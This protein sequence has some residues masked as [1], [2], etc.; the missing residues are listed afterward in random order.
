[1]H[2]ATHIKVENVLFIKI[3]K[4]NYAK[5]DTSPVLQGIRGFKL[6]RGRGWKVS[7]ISV[8]S[9]FRRF[10]VVFC[11][12]FHSHVTSLAQMNSDIH[13]DHRITRLKDQI[14]QNN[15]SH[16]I[17]HRHKFMPRKNHF[18]TLN[19]DLL[20]LMLI[21]QNLLS[22]S[23]LSR[24]VNINIYRTIILPAVLYGCETWSLALREE[25]RLRI[26]ENWVL[27]RTF[28]S[29]RDKV[30]GGRRKLHNKEL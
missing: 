19:R 25:C 29:K 11:Q 12:K 15:I 6:G 23:L 26:F 2:G 17:W 10:F 24:S 30:T 8:S 13:E 20:I 1:M 22:S 4:L 28:G 21:S 5:S 16:F 14:C 18:F 27:R 3:R 7:P 9:A